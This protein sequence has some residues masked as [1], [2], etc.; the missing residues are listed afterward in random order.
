VTLGPGDFYGEFSLIMGRPRRMTATAKTPVRAFVLTER[1]FKEL[2]RSNPG[3]ELKV[4]RSL[5]EWVR[6]L[7]K[8][9][10]L[11]TG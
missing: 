3:V 6:T 7:L 8:D 9:P 10:A 1:H 11:L 2:L 4:M 5:A